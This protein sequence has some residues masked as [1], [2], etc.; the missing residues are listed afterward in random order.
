LFE[1][2]NEQVVTIAAVRHQNEDD[3]H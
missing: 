1:I 2:E 3:Y